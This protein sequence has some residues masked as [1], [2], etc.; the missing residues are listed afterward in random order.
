MSR[1]P[2]EGVRVVDLCWLWAGAFATSILAV[3]GAEVI[4]VESAARPDP[5]RLI[6][7]TLGLEFTGLDSSPVFNTIN[8]NKLSIRL[9][10]KDPRA[11]ELTKKIVMTSDVVAQNWRPGVMDYM[12]L[13]YEALRQSKPDLI[14][15]S[16]SSYGT[17]GSF[18]TYGGYALSFTT[19]SG[20]AHLTG[21]VDE[22]P[23]PMTGSTD[24]MSA[25]T[26]AFAIVAALCHRQRTGRGQHIDVSSAE[27]LTVF[28]G[29]A[30]MDYIMNG[31]VQNR[32]G[33]KDRIMAPHNC[34]RCRGDGKW[35][36]IAVATDDEW[37]A[38]SDAIGNLE[39][40]ADDRFSDIHGRWKN[41][42]ELDRLV[43][44][45]TINLTHYE[46]TEILQRARVAAAP[47]L[48]KNDLFDDAQFK[49]RNMALEIDNSA[50]GKQV[51]IAHPWRLSKTPT[52]ITRPGP[53]IGEHN[54][55]IFGELLGM[56]NNEIKQL[57][58]EKVIY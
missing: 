17:K 32:Q 42:E 50:I 35:V 40:T 11:I 33:N 31:R 30:I 56:S 47:A 34:Y 53:L 8:L 24:L 14:M 20:L 10:L 52:K 15:L 44:G 18:R 51:V 5:S 1:A 26:S 55:Y 16:S 43:E 9:N 45:W 57:E 21:H 36:S 58:A 54:Q 12:G 13:G 48:T 28:T 38:F 6:V 29:D 7:I 22:S 39:W 25:T 46:V 23:N 27:S 4:K 41:Q 2:L 37:K 3:M 19:H 49:A